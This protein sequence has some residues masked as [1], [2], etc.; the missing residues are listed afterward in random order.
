MTE[1]YD[2]EPWMP[3]IS[4]G[5]PV[6]TP[7]FVPWKGQ[8]NPKS[9]Y[10]NHST[11]NGADPAKIFKEGLH[12]NPEVKSGKMTGRVSNPTGLPHPPGNKAYFNDLYGG[13]RAMDH[14]GTPHKA[15]YWAK[16]HRGS[17]LPKSSLHGSVII[18]T[19]VPLYG[20]KQQPASEDYMKKNVK[21]LDKKPASHEGVTHKDGA[22][23]PVARL[24]PK[25]NVAFFPEGSN[26]PMTK[27]GMVT[28]KMPMLR[29]LGGSM[30]DMFNFGPIQNS[31]QQAMPPVPKWI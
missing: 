26:T 14:L 13:P 17:S 18:D 30:I 28:G 23:K 2:I 20:Q 16:F 12:F 3:G 11:Y 24:N 19:K 8:L 9:T 29:G 5:A 22:G 27:P 25:S 15:A 31:E 1:S 21:L 7:D 4:P 10:Y 6:P